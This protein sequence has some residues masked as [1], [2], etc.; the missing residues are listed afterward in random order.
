MK[1]LDRLAKVR[2]ENPHI[3]Q[4]LL[5]YLRLPVLSI[6]QRKRGEEP[7]SQIHL[8]TDS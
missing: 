2:R 4:T 6:A 1:W 3:K 8:L 7:K 5:R